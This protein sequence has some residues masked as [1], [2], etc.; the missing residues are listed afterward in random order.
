[1]AGAGPSV[2]PG[3]DGLPGPFEY[4][5]YDAQGRLMI[6]ALFVLTEAAVEEI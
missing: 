4:S 1:M 2:P 6:D 5:E 3:G